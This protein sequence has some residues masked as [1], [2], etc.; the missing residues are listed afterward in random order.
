MADL[1]DIA[2]E[3]DFNEEVM[4]R[5]RNQK[6]VPLAERGV[7]LYCEATIASDKIYCDADCRS[8]HEHEERI[9]R[10]TRA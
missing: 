5:H 9:R 4:A 6:Q 7:C 3:H 1:A 2:G 8:M 10:Q